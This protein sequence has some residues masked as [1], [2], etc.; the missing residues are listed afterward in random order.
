MV[1]QYSRNKDWRWPEKMKLFK[2]SI[3]C[4]RIIKNVV[5]DNLIKSGSPLTWRTG[6][7]Y[8]GILDSLSFQSKTWIFEVSFIRLTIFLHFLYQNEIY[9]GFRW[10]QSDLKGGTK[11]SATN[12]YIDNNPIRM[13]KLNMKHIFMA[14]SYFVPPASGISLI[15]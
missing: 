12:R 13:V 7:W 3:R 8:T 1:V 5:I 11:V 9:N 2:A 14:G 6:I 4:K 10:S 15:R